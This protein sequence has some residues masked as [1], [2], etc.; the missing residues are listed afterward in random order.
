LE[1]K[2]TIITEGHE[3]TRNTGEAG[4]SRSPTRLGRHA[5]EARLLKQAHENFNRKA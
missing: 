4:G 3:P 2:I 1:E 5:F